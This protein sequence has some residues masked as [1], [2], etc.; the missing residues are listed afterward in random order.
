MIPGLLRFDSGVEVDDEVGW[1]GQMMRGRCGG[2]C[3]RHVTSTEFHTRLDG[4][5]C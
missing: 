2:G 3:V 5:W 4:K 1:V